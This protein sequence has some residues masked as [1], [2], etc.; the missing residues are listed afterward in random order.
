MDEQRPQELTR[1]ALDMALQRR[2]PLPGLMHHSDRGSQDAAGAYQK[3]LAE[4]AI[5]GSMSRKGNGW[6]PV[7]VS[8]ANTPR[9]K[10]CA[11]P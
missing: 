5:V 2:R 8:E 4:H 11:T 9:W 6:E 7:R 1:A 10:V 3:Q